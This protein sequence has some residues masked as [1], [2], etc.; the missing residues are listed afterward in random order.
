MHVYQTFG[1][2]KLANHFSSTFKTFK[3]KIWFKFWRIDYHLPNLPIFYLS[4]ISRHMVSIINQTLVF[5]NRAATNNRFNP[6]TA[7]P[8]DT[9]HNASE[10]T[11]YQTTHTIYLLETIYKIVPYRLGKPKTFLD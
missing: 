1:S 4:N 2:N 5:F 7:K 6:F 8:S 3:G 11:F 9:L 10:K